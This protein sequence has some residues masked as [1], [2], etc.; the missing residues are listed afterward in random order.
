MSNT[1]VRQVGSTKCLPVIIVK[2]LTSDDHL[3]SIKHKVTF[4]LRILKKVRPFLKS[5]NLVD[6]YSSI[7]KPYFSFCC[8]VWDSIADTLG[9]R[10]EEEVL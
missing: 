3:K 5:E 2:N 8:I 1:E 4:N 6:L 9:P 10:E 7:V